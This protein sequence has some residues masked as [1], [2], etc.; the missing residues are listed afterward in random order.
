MV[1]G[2]V[3]K[4]DPHID[5]ESLEQF[6]MGSLSARAVARVEE[7]LL[8]CEQCRQAC[9]ASDSYVAAIADAAAVLRRAGRKAASGHTKRVSGGS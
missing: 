4:T 9:A 2:M 3:S 1:T 5:A 7:H 6:S 8:V